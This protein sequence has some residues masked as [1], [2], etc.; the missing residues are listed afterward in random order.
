[1]TAYFQTTGSTQLAYQNLQPYG[2]N[3]PPNTFR[4]LPIPANGQSC[5]AD[6]SLAFGFY[7]YFT[8]PPSNNSIP[9]SA[10]GL[11]APGLFGTQVAA[12]RQLSVCTS[13]TP[14]SIPVQTSVILSLQGSYLAFGTNV[15]IVPSTFPCQ[16]QSMNSAVGVTVGSLS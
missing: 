10:T 1:M 5:I 3:L 14:T 9:P 2:A 7:V 12:S 8:V 11:S 13:F 15:V 16:G 4:A 6:Y